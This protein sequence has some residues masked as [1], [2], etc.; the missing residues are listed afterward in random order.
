[1]I[2]IV[3]VYIFY[4]FIYFIYFIIH[5]RFIHLNKFLC[6]VRM[7]QHYS[8]YNLMRIINQTTDL[9]VSIS[10]MSQITL[11]LMVCTTGAE[12]FPNKQNSM[13]L[14]EQYN[15]KISSPATRRLDRRSHFEYPMKYMKF[16]IRQMCCND[17]TD[18]SCTRTR[19]S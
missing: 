6:L 5:N 14:V 8:N 16:P 4:S 9:S 7:I 11:M 19:D 13:R 1:M 12:K 17:Q 15:F 10:L 18:H 3:C 2:A